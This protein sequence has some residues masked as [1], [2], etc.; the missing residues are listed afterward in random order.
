MLYKLDD[1]TT[2]KSTKTFIDFFM[3]LTDRNELK[4]QENKRQQEKLQTLLM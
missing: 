4:D 2:E 3:K 1:C